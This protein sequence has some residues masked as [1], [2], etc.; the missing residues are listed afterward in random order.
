[1][2]ALA[3]IST[4]PVKANDQCREIIFIYAI[5][6]HM[7]ND[8]QICELQEILNHYKEFCIAKGVRFSNH[9]LMPKR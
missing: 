7:S 5:C 4:L 9:V 6:V 2:S 8:E 3:C 1:M